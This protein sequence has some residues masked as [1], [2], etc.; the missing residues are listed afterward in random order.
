ME[1]V[2]CVFRGWKGA[3]EGDVWRICNEYIIHQYVSALTVEL[4]PPLVL[5]IVNVN[6]I[7]LSLLLSWLYDK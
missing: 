2:K 1:C 3:M 6:F 4:S 7:F 5:L